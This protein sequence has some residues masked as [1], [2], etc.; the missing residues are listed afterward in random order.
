MAMGSPLKP[1]LRFQRQ[2]F[3]LTHRPEAGLGGAEDAG[4]VEGEVVE[5]AGAAGIAAVGRRRVAEGG[6]RPARMAHCL[7]DVVTPH[8]GGRVAS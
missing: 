7:G 4:E 5:E 8:D 1:S 6:S 3:Y 2:Q